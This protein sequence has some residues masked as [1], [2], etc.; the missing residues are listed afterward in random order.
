MVE[1]DGQKYLTS[2]ELDERM[3]KFRD[4]EVEKLRQMMKDSDAKKINKKQVAHV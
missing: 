2:D 1:F 4:S 3:K